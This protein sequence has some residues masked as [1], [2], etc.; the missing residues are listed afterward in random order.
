MNSIHDLIQ[1]SLETPLPLS[2]QQAEVKIFEGSQACPPPPP[3]PPLSI[4]LVTFSQRAQW[5]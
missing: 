1:H 2:R 3:P 4:S 5:M